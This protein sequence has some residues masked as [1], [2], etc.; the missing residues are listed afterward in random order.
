[1]QGG[2][3]LQQGQTGPG[4]MHVSGEDA[5]RTARAASGARV[6]QASSPPV[7]SVNPFALGGT[8][9]APTSRPFRYGSAARLDS[10]A[11]PSVRQARSRDA[12][13][14]LSSPRIA[15]GGLSP[16]QSQDQSD[17]YTAILTRL[18]AIE[19]RHRDHA[20]CMADMMGATATRQSLVDP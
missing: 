9:S 19:S 5:L 2:V 18:D 13:R 17:A 1:M 3:P 8:R 7:M 10:P 4:P 6:P 15:S 14:P 12:R 11:P 20:Q 16:M